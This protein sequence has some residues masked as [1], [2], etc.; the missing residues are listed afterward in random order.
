M[1][2]FIQECFQ[3]WQKPGGRKLTRLEGP[4][5]SGKNAA[6]R[7]TFDYNIEM[8]QTGGTASGS[9]GSPA[10]SPGMTRT[11]TDDADV[12]W[13]FNEDPAA[14]AAEMKQREAARQGAGNEY[15]GP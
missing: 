4:N 11:S 6:N 3:E 2:R 9:P 5:Y 10:S 13:A 1:K 15:T 14:K 7:D 8:W 12:D